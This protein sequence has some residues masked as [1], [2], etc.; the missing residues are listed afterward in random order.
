MYLCMAGFLYVSMQQYFWAE[1]DM[2]IQ[3]SSIKT[4]ICK[5]VK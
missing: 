1:A 5:D 3:L 4:E 2:S